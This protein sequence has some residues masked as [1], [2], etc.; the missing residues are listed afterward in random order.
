MSVDSN[1]LTF[2]VVRPTPDEKVTEEV[3]LARGLDLSDC[4][5]LGKEGAPKLNA[6][7]HQQLV[8][9]FV[10]EEAAIARDPKRPGTS[11]Y[12]LIRIETGDNEPQ[13]SKPY[14]VPHRYQE[15]VRKEVAKLLRNGLISPCMSPWASP[16]LVVVK[17]DSGAGDKVNLKLAIDLRK[18]NAVTVMDSGAIGSMADILDKFCGRPY[19]SCCDISSGYYSFLLHP[20]D[21]KKTC[22]VLPYSMGGT[23]FC[24]HR[25]PYGIARLPAEFSRAIMTILTGLHDEVSSYIDDLCTHTSSFERHLVALKAMLRR[26]RMAAR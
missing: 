24:W 3:L 10:E 20:D 23:T 17:K 1:M 21:R 9:V 26:L 5:D 4:R 8:D 19:A 12:M 7:Q 15:E 18:L 14:T 6:E 13:A 25:A 22:F 2:D 11:D 16:V